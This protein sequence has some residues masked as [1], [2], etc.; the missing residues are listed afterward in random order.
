MG[1]IKDYLLKSE[2]FKEWKNGYRFYKPLFR[3]IVLIIVFICAYVAYDAGL[4]TYSDKVLSFDFRIKHYVKCT[5]GNDYDETHPLTPPC[6][7]AAYM[8]DLCDE[9]DD[10]CFTEFVNEGGDKPPWLVKHYDLV[11][12][13]TAIFG[14][15][16]N[17]LLF[18]W[19]RKYKVGE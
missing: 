9:F 7:N 19:N 18:N 13:I 16:L 1:K 17:H 11:L 14:F 4:I 10:F 2:Y 3:T 6:Q 8:S 5:A 15:G 12:M